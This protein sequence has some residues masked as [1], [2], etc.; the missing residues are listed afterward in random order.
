MKTNT[1]TKRRGD[2]AEDAALEHLQDAGLV[3]IAR[4]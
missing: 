4:N 2:A 1:T 3:L